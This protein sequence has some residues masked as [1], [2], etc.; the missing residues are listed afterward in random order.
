M[1]MLKA[2][3]FNA[4]APVAHCAK[5]LLA[6]EICVLLLVNF[7]FTATAAPAVPSAN[8]SPTTFAPE[9]KAVNVST[10]RDGEVTHFYVENKE[11]CEITMTFDQPQR[12]ITPGQA[13]VLYDGDNVVGGGWII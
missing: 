1:Q 11:L 13:V 6:C 10:R 4:F 3:S 8:G 12:A 5:R 9:A 2:T 7:W